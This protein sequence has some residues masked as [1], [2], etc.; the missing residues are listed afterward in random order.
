MLSVEAEG[1]ESLTGVLQPLTEPLPLLFR[2]RAAAYSSGTGL[3]HQENETMQWETSTNPRQQLK[4][5]P[6]AA[7]PCLT[8]PKNTQTANYFLQVLLTASKLKS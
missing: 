2:A 6:G 3:P 8:V 5:A 1:V 4:F 7:H